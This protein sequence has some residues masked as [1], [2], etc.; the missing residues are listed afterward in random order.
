MFS[1]DIKGNESHR[2]GAVE[3]DHRVQVMNSRWLQVGEIIRHP[4]SGELED[5]ESFA[6][7]EHF[8]NPFVVER[9][10]LK[11]NF[12]IQSGSDAVDGISEHRKVRESQ[13]IEFQ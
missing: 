12:F 9:D 1:L 5:A 13:K 2:P 3:R 6:A 4:T 8:V 11:I 10:F 7:R